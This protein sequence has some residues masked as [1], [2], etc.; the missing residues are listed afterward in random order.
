[1][2]TVVYVTQNFVAAEKVKLLLEQANI[3]VKMRNTAED[4][5]QPDTFEI[6]V[7]DTEIQQAHGIIIDIDD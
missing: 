7:P 5:T 3:L 6:L 2:W 4:E 1:M